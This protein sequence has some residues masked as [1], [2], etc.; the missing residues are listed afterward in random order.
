M[1]VY[2]LEIS[3]TIGNN[4][5]IRRSIPNQGLKFNPTIK[6]L[7]LK[8]QFFS[9]NFVISIA[10]TGSIST[11]GFKPDT[12]LSKLKEYLSLTVVKSDKE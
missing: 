7:S 10:K 2:F 5:S 3:L 12:L 8:S 6:E 4:L 1:F 11:K 9:R